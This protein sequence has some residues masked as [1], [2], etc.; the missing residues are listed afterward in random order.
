MIPLALAARTL[1]TLTAPLFLPSIMIAQLDRSRPPAPAPPPEV[2]LAEYG[3][4]K[5]SNGMQVIVVENH[6]LPL[7][8]V[9]LRFDIP[10]VVQGDKA[11]YVDMV[12]DL[13]PAGTGLRTKAQID[14]EIDRAGAHL[15]TTNDGM[16]AGGL[17][18]NLPQIMDVLEDVAR[19]A[20]FPETE[21]ERVRTRMI[22]SVKQRQDDPDAIAEAVGR[23]VTF[24]KTHPYG[25][26]TTEAT[27]A[28]IKREQVVAYYKRFFRPEKGYLVFIGDIT[29]K[30]AKQIAKKRFG[31]WKVPMNA[32]P[33]EDGTETVEGL[34]D[35]RTLQKP[36]TAGGMRRVSYVDRPGAAQSVIRVSFPLILPPNDI[37]AMSAQVMNTIL[38]GGVFNARLMQNLRERNA[39][40]YGAYSSLEIDRH[41]S[42]F[43]AMVSVRTEVTD[44]AVIEIL[45]EIERLAQEPITAEELELA[46]NYMAG[47]FARSLEDPRTVARFALNTFLND[48]PKDHY[49]TYL[50]RLE[51]I[52]TSDVERAAQTFLHPDKAIIFVVGDKE[53]I[54]YKLPALSAN[55]NDRVIE[56][57][58]DGDMYRE[59]IRPAGNKTAE[60]VIE[61]YL[62]AI[63]GREAIEK[64]KNV[65]MRL[66]T[67]IQGSPITVN[68]WYGEGAKFRSETKLHH[69]HTAEVEHPE[70][71]IQE[72]V[73][74]GDRA[75]SRTPQGMEELENAE[76]TE[77]KAQAL[78][79]PE[80]ETKRY[81]ERMSLSGITEVNGQEAYK[82]TI[83]ARGGAIIYDY[84]AVDSGLKL[85]RVEKK[86]VMGRPMT[87]TTDYRDHKEV[88]GVKFAH[89]IEQGGGPMGEVVLTLWH[90]EAGKAQPPGF[91]ETGLP[92]ISDEVEE[93]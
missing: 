32:I 28:N 86:S 92:P 49:A 56:L 55:P 81:A 41:N 24:G 61:N 78:P 89:K 12:G 8:N 66:G 67:T 34:G 29:E 35:V 39:F 73:F 16:Y 25:E 26:I 52:T 54:Q 18:K 72:V 36:I 83:T 50:Q 53:K 57:D 51:A 2:L 31:D 44:S 33:N 46:K 42:S 68:Q 21:L 17:K 65:Y 15:Y 47:S 23:S 69:P 43:T 82:V 87:I 90:V 3:S 84:F 63:G 1:F 13:L 74:D 80:L 60:E 71:V 27:L 58:V 7:V 9:Q 75:M 5:L 59:N 45:N 64:L 6:K 91:F 37:R 10:P 76:L 77:V 14:E 30:E 70:E 4:F 62:E 79:V 20:T 40:T 11:G 19:N 48:L 38:G 22:S 85:R 93:E 88:E